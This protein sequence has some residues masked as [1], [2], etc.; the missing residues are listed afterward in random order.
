MNIYIFTRD[1]RL[2]D[3]KLLQV[4][5]KKKTLPIFI[6]NPKQL[7]SQ[8]ASKKL[9]TFMI[10][11]LIDLDKELRLHKSKLNCYYGDP[12]E[13]IETLCKEN[14]VEGIYIMADYS[15]FAI[16]RN[17]KIRNIA[18]MYNALF[19]NDDTQIL[20]TICYSNYKKFTYYY[21]DKKDLAKLANINEY[22]ITNLIKNSSKKIDD[23]K[24]LIIEKGNIN[25]G[26]LE[27]LK[28]LENMNQFKNYKKTRD[29]VSI[30][31]TR[32]SAYMKFGV[33]SISEIILASQKD[34]KDLIRQ[35]M[36]RDFYYSL[37]FNN[38]KILDGHEIINKIKWR[39]INNE[40]KKDWKAW[41][42][43]HTGF[44]LCDAGMRE[45]NETGFMHNRCRMLV[46]YVLAKLL[47]I[48]WRH[49]EKYFAQHLIDYDWII[50]SMNWQNVLGG[51]YFAMPH[52][53]I[54][55]PMIQLKKY[56]PNCAYI[57]YWLPEIKDIPNK[58]LL[59]WDTEYKKYN[60]LAPI[61]DYNKAKERFLKEIKF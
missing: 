31:T 61:C 58:D 60:V 51:W 6:F 29:I 57:K 45:L 4:A 43:G 46:V 49:G 3:N 20:D 17:E 53:R 25:G 14:N 13:I 7:K 33:V 48:S 22:P 59:K 55:N 56:D 30:P 26:R 41:R 19:I 21:N 54:M 12:I 37:A 52:F 34:A 36:W 39:D 16:E 24:Y 10:E 11:S 1:L 18:K 27:A 2:Y 8:Y 38:I 15:P 40:A 50:N 5:L 44:L 23:F 28:I 32:L 47:L 9:I 42:L 35:I